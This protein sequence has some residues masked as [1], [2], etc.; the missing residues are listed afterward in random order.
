MKVIGLITGM[1]WHSSVDYYR[2]INQLVAKGLGVPT[3]RAQ[4]FTALIMPSG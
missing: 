4:F 3:E 2:L 1:S